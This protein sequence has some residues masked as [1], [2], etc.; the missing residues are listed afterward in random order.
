[1]LG[2]TADC[3]TSAVGAILHGD[4]TR[5]FARVVIDSRAV[6][7]GDLFVALR[8]ARTDGH[9]H[10]RQAL[11][12][13][14]AAAL[15]LPD[16]QERPTGLDYLVVPDTLTALA[17][18]ARFHFGRLQAKV[19][20][21]TGSVGKT[22]AKD[23]LFQLL[24]GAQQNI[25]AAPAS[26]NSEIGLPLAILAAPLSTKVLIL[27][28]GINAPG[29]ME[30]LLG[31][32]RP[33]QA[34]ITAIAPAHLE[35]LVDL[36]TV[37]VEKAKLGRSV[38]EQNRVWLDSPC[39][40]KIHDLTADW[41]ADMV[42]VDPFDE[43]GWRILCNQPGAVHVQ[44]PVWG[45]LVLPLFARHQ[46]ATA[47]V[48][49]RIAVDHHVSITDLCQRLTQLQAPPGRLTVSTINQVTVI[50]DAYNA[51]PASMAAALELLGS[52]PRRGR[53]I[54]V[55]GSMQELGAAAEVLHRQV[56]CQVAEI[57]IDLLIGVGVGGTWIAATA[58][59]QVAIRLV[60]DVAA[61]A[62]ILTD[63]LQPHDIVLLKASRSEGLEKILAGLQL[64]H[65]AGTAA[66][67]V[68]GGSGA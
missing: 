39:W 45:E 53:R 11:D 50:D 21:I 30:V 27:E 68:D 41:Q 6:Q 32:A 38:L 3:V 19:I 40:E 10:L 35:G 57:G 54:A 47:F 18:L 16:G 56:G 4:G 23:F 26:Y 14:A 29:E 12:Q 34:W 66:A 55:L 36:R 49:A 44:H 61:A 42:K 25:F 9:L 24:G 7:P 48:A 2:L 62:E 58:G 20:G 22:T 63:Y 5:E 52:W 46:I 43:S 37:A 13:G 51:N 17:D 59:K 31:I 60:E 65:L 1:M 15:V 28:Y 8:G 64:R 33:H 67:S